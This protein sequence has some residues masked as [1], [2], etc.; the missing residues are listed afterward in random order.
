MTETA[1]PAAMHLRA[2]R[3]PV[4]G[5]SGVRDWTTAV[6]VAADARARTQLCN[7]IGARLGQVLSG[8]RLPERLETAHQTG[9]FQTA[10]QLASG[11]WCLAT[12]TPSGDTL[13]VSLTPI[14]DD[15]VREIVRRAEP[16]AAGFR[17]AAIGKAI[18]DHAGHWLEVNGYLC[19]LLG[20]SEPELQG[21]RFPHLIHPDDLGRVLAA[22]ERLVRGEVE[23][24]SVEVRYRRRVGG[25]VWCEVW[26]ELHVGLL[27]GPAPDQPRF[28]IYAT[29]ITARKDIA[30]Q[31]SLSEQRLSLALEGAGMAWWE[32]DRVNDVHRSSPNMAALLGFA[33]GT[34]HDSLVTFLDMVHPDDRAMIAEMNANPH[35]WRDR[36]EYRFTG[37]DGVER[38]LESRSKTVYASDGSVERVLG[39]STDISERKRQERNL[40]E[41][42]QRLELALQSAAMG[43]WSWD[44][45]QDLMQAS[46]GFARLLGYAPAEFPGGARAFGERLDPEEFERM[47]AMTEDPLHWPANYSYRVYL[48]GGE[49]RWISSHARVF[50]DDTGR[51]VRVVGVDTDVTE[52]QRNER[53]LQETKERLELALSSAEMGW[54]EWDAASD[55]HRWSPGF[56]QLLGYPPNAYQ[57]SHEAFLARVHPEDRALFKLDS[58]ALA[59]W[60]EDVDYRVVLSSGEERWIS[61]RS[62][63]IRGAGGNVERIIGVDVDITVRKRAEADLVRRAT[64]DPLTDLPNRRTFT[65]RLDHA[66]QMARRSNTQ[67]AVVFLDLDRFKVINDTLGHGAG[68][69]LLRVVARRL[70]LA[71]R[72]DDTIARLGGDEFTMILP[73]VRNVDNGTVV[74]QKLL[75]AFEDP[76]MLEGQEVQIGAS[77]GISLFPGDGEDSATLL[78]H[79]DDAKRRAKRGGRNQYQFYRSEMTQVAHGQLQLERDLRRALEGEQFELHYQP[80]FALGSGMLVGVEALLRWRHPERGFVPPSQFIPIAEESGLIVPIGNWV[81]HEACAQLARWRRDAGLRVRMAVNV[82]TLQFERQDLLETV[83]GALEHHPEL[84]ARFLE[85]ELTESL[86]MRDVTGSATQLRALRELGVQVAVDDFGTGYSSLAYLQRLPID[87][88]KIDRAFINDL[89]GSP[90]DAAP[91]VQAIIALA[92]TLGMEVVAEGIETEAQVDTLQRLR[93]EIGQGYLLGRPVPADQLLER[94]REGEHRAL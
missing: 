49:V 81:L 20:Y 27:E 53:E 50:F 82:S 68:D 59:N 80:Q 54:W 36:F 16:R 7:P 64:H 44:F 52:R 9:A 93:C 42:Q 46:D 24:F 18:L 45:S 89:G 83:R 29:D 5:D 30:V 72:S 67:L 26:C 15:A 39:V 77:L 38:W 1:A 87:R 55:Q 62:K 41:A 32:H 91:L 48:P 57:G 61:S 73:A 12:C 22:R 40:G 88:L 14:P 85:L 84:E 78:R 92:H 74:A 60:Q 43:W 19:A 23:R 86:V 47:R 31:L 34:Y 70:T 17:S 10:V 13:E 79:A 4:R 76:F 25:E 6:V 33:P 2:Q 3:A 37:P 51:P 90:F 71:L 35:T 11:S 56:E 75:S 69:A 8:L 21:L 28:L 58:H 94:L 63:V 66:I 65:E